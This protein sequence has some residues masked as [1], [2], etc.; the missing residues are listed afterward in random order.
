MKV[1]HRFFMACKSVSPS[2]RDEQVDATLPD[3]GVAC[4]LF[5]VYE[6]R[7]MLSFQE[8]DYGTE[9]TSRF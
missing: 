3:E 9:F 6:L 4:M 7:P 2:V 5:R 1:W 8:A